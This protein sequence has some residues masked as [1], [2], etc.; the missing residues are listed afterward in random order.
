MRVRKLREWIPVFLLSGM[1]IDWIGVKHLTNILGVPEGRAFLVPSAKLLVLQMLTIK[2]LGCPS[3][4]P[5]CIISG[6]Q[7]L[8]VGVG[9]QEGEVVCLHVL[10]YDQ[11]V[12]D[13]KKSWANIKA[14]GQPPAPLLAQFL[15]SAQDNRMER[16]GSGNG[17]ALG[18]SGSGHMDTE[19]DGKEEE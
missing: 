9:A 17:N 3:V 13:A 15:A 6:Q 5:Q 1:N 2:Q 10:H 8:G 18:R 14:S 12:F 16:C 11:E 7:G 4:S 19:E